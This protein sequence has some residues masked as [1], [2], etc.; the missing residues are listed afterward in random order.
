MW[1][2]LPAALTL[3]ILSPLVAEYLLGSLPVAMIGI[4]PIMA[5]MYGSAAVL[6]REIVRR[7]GRGWPSIALLACA[8][9][10]IE[11]G[12]VTQSL[13]NPNYLGLRLL[14]FG[15]IPAFGTSLPWLVFVVSIHVV[16]SMC[17]PIGLAEALFRGKRD[18]P[19]LGP[20]GI[21]V[22]SLLFLVGCVLIAVFTY[23]QWPY[24]AS[25]AKLTTTGL[26]VAALVAAAL[27]WPRA[28]EATAPAPHAV[29]IFLAALVPGSALMELQQLAASRLHWNWYWCV[30]A[31]VAIEA[32]FIAFMAFALAKVW[33]DRQRF[34]MV[35]GGF[36]TYVWVGFSTDVQL[37]G[38]A[39]LSA[40]AVLAVIMCLV[41]AIA[42]YRSL[43]RSTGG[44][45]SAERAEKDS[46]ALV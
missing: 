9:G 31:L 24:M 18:Q 19:W 13:F 32:S 26:I 29:V 35:A 33:T 27:K 12:F 37:H 34:A 21:V 38:A 22:F 14:D 30:I 43:D 11:E 7:S 39:D 2:R 42:G 40:H 15:F 28:K 46:A 25:A 3:F 44:S 17:V 36:L 5:L 23:R 6:I 10:F 20:I 16:W 8:Y 45:V 1:R 4:L 41:L